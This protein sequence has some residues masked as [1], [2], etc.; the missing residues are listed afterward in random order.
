MCSRS[1]LEKSATSHLYKV[2]NRTLGREV[3]K[4]RRLFTL[5]IVCV[6]NK[7][8]SRTKVRWSRPRA[9][10]MDLTIPETFLLGA[11]TVIE[12]RKRSAKTR[13]CNSRY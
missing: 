12:W 10:A 13:N 3:R 6:K 8:T 7:N 11:D 4:L 2:R 5:S 1:A 9:K